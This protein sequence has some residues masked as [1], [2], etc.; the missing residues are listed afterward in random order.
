MGSPPVEDGAIHEITP[1]E[2][3]FT[4][5]GEYGALAGVTAA[6]TVEATPFPATLC[7]TT[8][9]VYAVPLVRPVTLQEVVVV[10]QVLPPGEEVTV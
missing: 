3:A 10:M 2:V 7:A 8:L 1:P 6:E 4:P 9:K 5:V